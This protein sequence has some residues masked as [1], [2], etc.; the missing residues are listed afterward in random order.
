MDVTA[1]AVEHASQILA[2]IGLVT[3]A[4]FKKKLTPGGI[5][6]AIAVAIVHMLDPWPVFFWLLVPF[7]LL[8]V[9]VTKIGHTAKASL[10]KSSTGSHGGEGARSS[11]QV[12]ANS[13]FAS[14]LIALHTYL[15]MSTP[16]ISSNVPVSSGP[17]FPTLQK[18]LPI[19]IMAHYA[20][21]AADTFGSELGILAKSQPFLITAPWK[22]VPRGTN[23]GVT[24][25]G[26]AFGA[27][28]SFLMTVIATAGIYLLHPH[29]VL[30][31]SAANLVCAMGLLGSV[32]DSVLGAT[33]QATIT[34][35][36]T[37]KVVEGPG[38]RR[39]KVAQG[40]SRVKLGRDV[41]TNNGVNLAMAAITSILAMA[42]AHT[43]G[44]GV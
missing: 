33:V 31:P 35:R 29:R 9:L 24:I 43:L 6:A 32:I 8:G 3:F 40:G 2:T 28:G 30:H 19:G 4:L 26:L 13:G 42:A 21:V 44:L 20:A 11:A 7:F 27:L 37:G 14:I 16:F 17:H 36:G 15:A 25:E 12:F 22:Q 23:G 1:F 39:V 5:L 38:G 34:D 41:L 10:T 18:L